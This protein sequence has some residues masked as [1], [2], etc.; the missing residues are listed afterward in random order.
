MEREE[1]DMDVSGSLSSNGSRQAGGGTAA[2]RSVF[3]LKEEERKRK[4]KF[5]ENPPGF[6]IFSEFTKQKLW[7]FI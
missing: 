5:S 7:E 6:Y 1:K 3:W 4:G 2:S